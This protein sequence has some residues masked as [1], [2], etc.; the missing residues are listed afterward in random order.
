[1]DYSTLKRDILK[2]ICL[3]R[4]IKYS[5]KMSKSVMIV[6]LSKND[7]DPN[8]IEDLETKIKCC[9]YHTTWLN[10]NRTFYN[11]YHK[12]YQRQYRAIKVV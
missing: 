9:G 10:K 12:T 5:H 8:I 3:S 11:S 6:M 1:M 2:Q 7:V 4:G